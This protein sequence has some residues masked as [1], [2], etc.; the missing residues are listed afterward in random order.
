MLDLAPPHV[1]ADAME[2]LDDAVTSALWNTVSSNA[3]VDHVAI[4]KLDGTSATAS[5]VPAVPGAWVGGRAGDTIPNMA[6]I[7]KL[8][9]GLRGRDRRGRLYLPFL[10]EG[11]QA[12]GTIT[13]ANLPAMQTA[14][15]NLLGTLTAD[16]WALDIA[17]YKFAH[18]TPVLSVLCETVAGTQRRRQSRLR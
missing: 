10:P 2:A 12:D 8:T 1:A 16:S 14:W 17:S 9:T 6:T 5:F 13:D 4:T 7:V 15:T 18:E 3:H 11:S